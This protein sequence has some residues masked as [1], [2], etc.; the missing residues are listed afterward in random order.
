M[1][2]K[3]PL[4]VCVLVLTPTAKLFALSQRSKESVPLVFHLSAHSRTPNPRLRYLPNATNYRGRLQLTN[5]SSAKRIPPELFRP[6]DE[7]ELLAQ[8]VC[9]LRFRFSFLS[10]ISMLKS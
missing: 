10:S 9:L 3:F 1:P 2:N 6:G 5:F 8:F 7:A 4:V